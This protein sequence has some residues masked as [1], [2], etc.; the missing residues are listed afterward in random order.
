MTDVLG[1]ETFAAHGTDWGSSVAYNLYNSYN[2]T[3]RASQLVFLP[4]YPLTPDQLAD[5]GIKLDTLE[6]FEEEGFLEWY[7]NG[8][9][10]FQEESTKVSRSKG[11]QRRETI[12]EYFPQPNTIGLALYDNPVG[13][14]AYIGEKFITCM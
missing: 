12:S 10:Y 9:G 11:H 3:V 5:D 6:E 2:S 13:Q 7:G 4:F 14:L 8:Q 1:Y